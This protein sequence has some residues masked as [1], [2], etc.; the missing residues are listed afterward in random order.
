MT[1]IESIYEMESMLNDLQKYLH[2]KDGWVVKR[3][4]DKYEQLVDRFFRENVNFIKPEKRYHCLHYDVYF[5]ALMK[6][7]RES[8]YSDQEYSP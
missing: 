4:P 2:S 5:L 3:A 8:Y 1:P 7:T 6:S